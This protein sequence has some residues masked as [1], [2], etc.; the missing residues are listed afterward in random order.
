MLTVF[1]VSKTAECLSGKGV[2]YEKSKEHAS[3]VCEKLKSLYPEAFIQ[4]SDQPSAGDPQVLE[5]INNTML[6]H[7]QGWIA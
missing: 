4:V 3:I 7:W 2:S 1:R 5:M 6:R